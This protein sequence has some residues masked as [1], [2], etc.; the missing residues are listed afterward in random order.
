MAVV[1]SNTGTV[2][3]EART[4]TNHPER[5]TLVACGRCLKPFC[6]ECLVHTPAGLRCYD[7][8]GVK[9]NYAARA[10]AARFA[11]AFGALLLGAAISSF[12]GFFSFFIAAAA[13]GYAGQL[14]SPTVTR[15]TRPWVYIPLA[16]VVFLGTWL[17]WSIAGVAGGMMT[18]AARGIALDPLRLVALPIAMLFAPRLWIY[19]AITAIAV[20]Q[21]DR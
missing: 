3:A 11:Q 13:G 17:G 14:L 2:G 6:T 9:R 15:H 20:L 4:C 21:R 10:G 18:M 12:V 1:K 7:C 8:A 5:E 16:L 19:F